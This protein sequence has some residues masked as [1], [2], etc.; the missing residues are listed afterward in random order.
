[1]FAFYCCVV[2]EGWAR[3]GVSHHSGHVACALL[4]QHRCYPVPQ[5]SNG[6]ARE[7][8]SY[9]KTA[10]VSKNSFGQH[11]RRR[12]WTQV[13]QNL[14]VGGSWV[15]RE[16]ARTALRTA[17]H[18]RFAPLLPSRQM[19]QHLG[20]ANATRA[21]TFEVLLWLPAGAVLSMRWPSA[22]SCLRPRLS[23]VLVLPGRLNPGRRAGRSARC[24]QTSQLHSLH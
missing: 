15:R 12:E 1:M 10:L 16:N 3:L 18:S 19:R 13:D 23:N 6:A 11:P 8:P 21:S 17:G 4:H 2:Q 7:S 5:R 24:L 14:C 20:Q 9:P 22:A